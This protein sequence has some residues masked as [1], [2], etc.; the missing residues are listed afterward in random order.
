MARKAKIRTTERATV[1]TEAA[2]HSRY[3]NTSVYLPMSDNDNDEWGHFRVSRNI[4]HNV[5]DRWFSEDEGF[6]LS[7]HIKAIAACSDMWD[8]CY[9][10]HS[11]E[12]GGRHHSR[13][14]SALASF[15]ARVPRYAWEIFE[16][17]CRWDE[18]TGVPGSRYSTVKSSHVRAAK[19]IVR[20]VAEEIFR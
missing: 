13:S 12:G 14:L 11:A 20:Y 17:V 16:N 6:W 18:P 3:Q 10:P 2:Q 5:I 7:Q 8:R 4:D 15:K 1:Q 19:H 9:R